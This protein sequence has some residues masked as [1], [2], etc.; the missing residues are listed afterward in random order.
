MRSI[1]FGN[2]VLLLSGDSQEST[3]LGYN[4]IS[5]VLDE[6]SFYYKNDKDE[7]DDAQN[8]YDQLSQRIKSRFGNEGFIAV[9]TSTDES[10]D[11]GER[12]YVQ[13]DKEQQT[14]RQRRST[15]RAKPRKSMSEKVF[16]FD[17]EK[18]R[19][20]EEDQ[21]KDYT[22][23]S[24]EKA[25]IAV[26]EEEEKSL[27][28]SN[29]ELNE[30][31]WIIPKDFLQDFIRNPEKASKDL[32]SK[33]YKSGDTFI[34]LQEMV[35][36]ACKD[37]ENPIDDDGKWQLPDDFGDGEDL[38]IHI[39][40][41]LNKEGTGDMAGL[42]IGHFTGHNVQQAGMAMVKIDLVE[43]IRAGESSEIRF[44]D[45]RSRFAYL[46]NKGFT[47]MMVTMD[48]W[49]SIDTQQ[50]LDDWGIPNE[51][52]SVDKTTKPYETLKESYYAKCIEMPSDSSRYVKIANRELK[53]LKVIKGKVDHP[54]D[55]T[56]DVG[57]SLAGVVFSIKDYYGIETEA[58][59]NIVRVG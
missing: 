49:Q 12:R 14:F 28:F 46:V 55:G 5:A 31:L 38:F 58:P 1:S 18:M 7:R 3:V 24:G 52:L 20:V 54:K 44:S 53:N 8:I 36:M 34:R 11:F 2:K 30:Y 40:L 4:V 22:R 6:A 15:W 33:P 10:D 29:D 47:I 50:I 27:R 43:Q 9:I 16:V 13:A 25:D 32:G 26:S 37:Y 57:D 35:D 45:V 21:F 19:V 48:G 39:D 41:A 23:K 17:N 59:V 42:A 56:K 51:E